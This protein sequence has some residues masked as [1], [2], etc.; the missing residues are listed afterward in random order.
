MASA[1]GYPLTKENAMNAKFRN[2]LKKESTF[3]VIVLWLCGFIATL[4]A[5]DVGVPIVYVFVSTI[6]YW[7]FLVRGKE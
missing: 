7:F 6:V 1:I 3:V 4:T 2:R 5:N